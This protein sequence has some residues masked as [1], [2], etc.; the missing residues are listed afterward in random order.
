VAV[1]GYAGYVFV[2]E[3]HKNLVRRVSLSDLKADT[4]AMGLMSPIGLGVVGR[5]G[6]GGGGGGRPTQLPRHA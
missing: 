1:D 6:G 3:R 2:E 5:G 4:F